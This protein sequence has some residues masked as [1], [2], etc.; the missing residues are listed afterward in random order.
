MVSIHY[1]LCYDL[2][3]QQSFLLLLD[4]Q[5]K[6]PS[7]LS[8]LSKWQILGQKLGVDSERL[9]GLEL[10]G[11]D[12]SQC[13]EEVIVLWVKKDHGASWEKLAHALDQMEEH[14]IS[15]RI[16]DT[17]TPQPSHQELAQQ[18]LETGNKVGVIVVK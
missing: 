13:M 7:V 11:K 14:E 9:A 16:K 12:P 10:S 8:N 2:T 1:K 6:A 15:R 5:Q 3:N 17:C 4:L 18:Q